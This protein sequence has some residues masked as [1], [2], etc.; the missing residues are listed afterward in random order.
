MSIAQIEKSLD[1]AERELK[2]HTERASSFRER[3][4]F[5]KTKL[6]DAKKKAVKKPTPKR[7]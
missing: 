4:R 3:I 1:V 2:R 7:K 6:K 5:L